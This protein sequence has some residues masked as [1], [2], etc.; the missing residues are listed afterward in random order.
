MVSI[1]FSDFF[2]DMVGGFW[3][4][5]LRLDLGPSRLATLLYHK[6]LLTPSQEMPFFSPC[7]LFADI[8]TSLRSD[9]AVMTMILPRLQTGVDGTTDN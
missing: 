4:L 2:Q 7:S 3:P 5:G 8:E 9:D 1:S 6:L